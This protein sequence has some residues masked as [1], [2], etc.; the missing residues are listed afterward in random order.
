MLLW[1]QAAKWLLTRN[2]L[3]QTSIFPPSQEHKSSPKQCTISQSNH[4]SRLSK[5]CEYKCLLLE[6]NNRDTASR[7]TYTSTYLATI[8][9]FISDTS[10]WILRCFHCGTTK[11]IISKPST[12]GHEKQAIW[13]RLGENAYEAATSHFNSHEETHMCPGRLLGPLEACVRSS[14]A[15][16]GAQVATLNISERKQRLEQAGKERGMG[17]YAGLV[18]EEGFEMSYLSFHPVVH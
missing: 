5:L 18:E 9:P 14:S 10:P 13:L 11:C 17:W 7:T 6:P 2:S 16:R 1:V 4:S 8:L 3:Q 12:L 15:E